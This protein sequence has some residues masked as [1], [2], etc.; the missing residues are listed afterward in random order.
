MAEEQTNPNPNPETTSTE[1]TGNESTLSTGLDAAKPPVGDTPGVDPSKETSPTDDTSGAPEK[2]SAWTLPDGY[3]LDSG[4]AAEAEPIFRELGL[5][6][7]SA[8]K[9]V[10]FYAKH[11]V[12]S[13]KEALDAWMETRKGWRDEMKSDPE[14]GKLVGKDGNFGPDSPLISTVFRALDGLQNPKL[15]ADFKAAMNLTG[16]G[17]NPA[18]V[19]VLHALA[20]KVTEGTTY[21]RGEPPAASQRR[22]TAG[23]A[24]YPNLP[25]GRA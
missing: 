22:P 7:E 14:L 10:D 24:L 11:A 4:V 21:V 12:A 19:R 13:S 17:D 16:A 15:V 25:S 3:E 6:Q 5:T 1:T 23:A 20:S 2:Y 8:Q 18:F 9:L